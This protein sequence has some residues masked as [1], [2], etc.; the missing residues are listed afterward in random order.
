MRAAWKDLRLNPLRSSLTALSLFIGILSIVIIVVGGAIARDYLV[1]VAEQRDGR[2]PTEAIG[3]VVDPATDVNGVR[4]L[5]DD[6]PQSSRRA[7]SAKLDLAEPLDVA[8]IPPAGQPVVPG[9]VQAMLVAGDLPGVR[10][11]PLV[12]GRWLSTD[13]ATAPF[14]VVVNE[15]AERTLGAV[16]SGVSLSGARD[17]VASTGVVVGVVN[18]GDDSQANAYVKAA[19][20]LAYAPQLAHVTGIQLLWHAPDDQEA[21]IASA[22]ADMSADAGLGAPD[23]PRRVDTVRTYLEPLAAVQAMFGVAAALALLVAAVG[24]VNVGLSSI[25]ERARELVIRRALGATRGQVFRLVMASSVLLAVMVAAA[26]V[27]V[28]ALVIALVPRFLPPDTPVTVPPY[29]WS[30]AA[31]ALTVS[32]L[33]AVV[34]SSIP[35]WRAARVEPATALRE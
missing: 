30:A 20:L 4:R 35:A 22:A 9:G 26:S 19:P 16:G 13:E 23:S 24:I 29:P 31:W 6:L 28:S 14:E 15:E 17:G 32:V 33:T 21:E 12:A 27:A 8:P 1:A 2:L 18:D 5:V 34:S 7:V 3:I 11:L 10:R 25:R